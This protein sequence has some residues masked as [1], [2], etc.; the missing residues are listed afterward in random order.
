MSVDWN[1][2]LISLGCSVC[3]RSSEV[4]RLCPVHKGEDASLSVTETESGPRFRCR[5]CGFTGDALELA[6]AATGRDIAATAHEFL[7]GGRFASAMTGALTRKQAEAWAAR[8]SEQSQARAWIADCRSA[9]KGARIRVHGL[10]SD[11]TLWPEEA[12][13]LCGSR[14]L[15]VAGDS[16]AVGASM[17]FPFTSDG[18]VRSVAYSYPAS[19]LKWDGDT[20][21]CGAGDG[22]F[23]EDNAACGGNIL[24][25]LYPKAAAAAA[26][27]LRALSSSRPPV[28]ALRGHT[29]P[30][31]WSGVTSITLVSGAD[32]LV[33]VRDL[34]EMTLVKGPRVWVKELDKALAEHGADELLRLSRAQVP[35]QDLLHCI[36]RR[37]TDELA[38]GGE[39]ELEDAVADSGI[40]PEKLEELQN[41]VTSPGLKK[42]LRKHV[43]PDPVFRLG[44]GASIRVGA[45]EL[46]AV[47]DKGRGQAISNF[48]LQVN[49]REVSDEDVRFNVTVVPACAPKATFTVSDPGKDGDKL[50][51]AAEAVY[52]ESG[53]VPYLHT[54]CTADVKWPDVLQ[55]LAETA[56]VRTRTETLGAAEDGSVRLP[57][58]ALDPDTGA[59]TCVKTEVTGIA[60]S[61]FDD[62]LFT[63]SGD[64]GAYR[65]LFSGSAISDIGLALAMT[66]MASLQSRALYY[67]ARGKPFSNDHLAFINDDTMDWERVLRRLCLIWHDT[68]KPVPLRERGLVTVTGGLGSLPAVAD[69][70]TYADALSILKIA[71]CGVVFGSGAPSR[72][73]LPKTIF[74]TGPESDTETEERCLAPSEIL[75]LRSGTAAFLSA[76]V[77]ALDASPETRLADNPVLASYAVVCGALGVEP[78]AAASSMCSTVYVRDRDGIVA[79]LRQLSRDM[80]TRP[81]ERGVLGVFDP[82]KPEAWLKSDIAVGP[83]FTALQRRVL[84][85]G[86]VEALTADANRLGLCYSGK[87]ADGLSRRLV[88]KKEA[89]QR[90]T[91][92]PTVPLSKTM[93]FG[94]QGSERTACG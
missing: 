13:I 15:Y 76:A 17:S 4:K 80:R 61:L 36:A 82:A 56:P 74:I 40:T 20:R 85:E 69:I 92:M 31:S 60:G 42:V 89:W 18:E 24:V 72:P 35:G 62:A 30:R 37:M 48:G 25:S 44:G 12:G 55:R 46:A 39:K 28:A 34:L 73:R 38:R 7:R 67:K 32:C 51:R 8:A 50:L 71:E 54:C 78:K 88:L 53:K 79:F 45:T 68:D 87:L 49:Y 27:R 5:V 64:I 75:A 65:D 26:S 9:A 1:K 84:G 57:G 41:V 58:V 66:H 33:S 43:K 91:V 47:S 77:K 19:P 59:V 11:S 63:G 16:G 83:E 29:L 93:L 6:A 2:L 21:V 3:D 14:L 86:R 52:A 70:Q 10:M 23:M 81:G 90:Y 94:S 22:V